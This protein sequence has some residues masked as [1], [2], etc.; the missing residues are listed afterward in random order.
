M[1][2]EVEGGGGDGDDTEGLFEYANWILETGIW[3]GRP[4]TLADAPYFQNEVEQKIAAMLFS[5]HPDSVGFQQMAAHLAWI[6]TDPEN[7]ALLARDIQALDFSSNALILQAGF[8]KSL[9]KFW[10]KHKVAILVGVSVLAAVTVVTAVVVC[11]GAAAAGAATAGG[12]ALNG[13]KKGEPEKKAPPPE[14]IPKLVDHTP[15]HAEHPP[16][17]PTEQ[18]VIVINTEILPTIPISPAARAPKNIVFFDR[19]FELNGKYCSYDEWHRRSYC[20]KF[21]SSLLFIRIREQISI[22]K[23]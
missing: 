19:G 21:F 14:P 15:P 18:K 1:S 23:L 12:A 6:G 10:K 20:D 13:L 22:Q 9:S 3:D 8:G 5:Q 7:R 4:I 2:T 17:P 11:S 16:S